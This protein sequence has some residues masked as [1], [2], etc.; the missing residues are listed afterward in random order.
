MCTAICE[1]PL[2]ITLSLSP[3]SSIFLSLPKV[4]LHADDR[5]SEPE[6]TKTKY[7]LVPERKTKAVVSA[8]VF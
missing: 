5:L 4:S 6:G 2:S 3:C 1:S 7:C 8:C